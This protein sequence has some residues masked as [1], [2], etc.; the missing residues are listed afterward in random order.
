LVSPARQLRAGTALKKARQVREDV[1]QQ[2]GVRMA[3]PQ[4]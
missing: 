1:P 4:R 3:I 2:A